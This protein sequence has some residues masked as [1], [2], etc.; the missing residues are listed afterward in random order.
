M[1]FNSF[2]FRINIYD[3]DWG[4][5]SQNCQLIHPYAITFIGIMLVSVVKYPQAISK[6][7]IN[8]RFNLKIS[9]TYGFTTVFYL[10]IKNKNRSPFLF[11]SR[12]GSPCSLIAAAGSFCFLTYSSDSRDRFR[13]ECFFPFAMLFILLSSK[14][15]VF[16]QGSVWAFG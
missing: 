1:P 16:F 8:L 10:E 3:S 11:A 7:S 15:T 12:L 6:A 9:V 4:S 13:Q 2:P 5:D 14:H